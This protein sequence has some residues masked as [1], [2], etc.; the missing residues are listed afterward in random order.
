TAGVGGAG[1]QDETLIRMILVSYIVGSVNIH[2][3]IIIAV[4]AQTPPVEYLFGAVVRNVFLAA[5][6]FESGHSE[7]E[8]LGHS[9]LPEFFCG[10]IGE[11][12]EWIVVVGE[13]LA[14]EV[15]M[16]R[17]SLFCH[18]SLKIW[19]NPKKHLRILLIQPFHGF[20]KIW[21]AVRINLK[22]V[23]TLRARPPGAI[24]PVNTVGDAISLHQQYVFHELLVERASDRRAVVIRG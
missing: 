24:N 11:I 19:S 3:G 22:I 16:F 1:H 4:L 18:L 9:I 10:G 13:S 12:S 5:V 6:H 17:Q 7:P 23:V 14:G 21:Q 2:D 15:V 8:Q 20:G